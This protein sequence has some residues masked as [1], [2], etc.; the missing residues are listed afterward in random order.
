MNLSRYRLYS[1]SRGKNPEMNNL[2][3]VIYICQ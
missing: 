1:A 3:M 2:T